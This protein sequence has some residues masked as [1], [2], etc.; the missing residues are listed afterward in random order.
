MWIKSDT[1]V[2]LVD[3]AARADTR[4]DWLMTRVNQLEMEVGSLRHEI[5]GKP[6]PVPVFRK[7]ATPALDEQAE[8]SFEDLGDE[9]AR[10]HGVD[11]P[12]IALA[13]A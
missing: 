13:P 11:W 1:Y 10:K 4:A 3:R 2:A 8:T 5:T 9:L 12:I 6:Q 7:D